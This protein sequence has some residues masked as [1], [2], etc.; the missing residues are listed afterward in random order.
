M[1]FLRRWDKDAL[2]KAED[3]ARRAEVRLREAI[4]LLPE[5]IV[6]LDREGRYILWNRRYAETYHASADLFEV[7]VRFEDSLRV[8]VARGDYPEALGREE[9]WLAE[10]LARMADPDERHEQRL[11]DG[12]WIMIEER[13]TADGGTIGIRVDITELKQQ[14]EA[15]RIALV[16]AE[17]ASKAKSDFLSNMS[18]EIRTPLNGV[19]GL[20]GVL[21]NGSLDPKQRS[22]V[23][24]IVA[25]ANTLEEL[26]TDLLM[27]S[28]LDAGALAL[29]NRPFRLRDVVEETVAHYR[30]ETEAK[31]LALT[32]DIQS[33]DDEE[34]LGDPGRIRQVL[35]NFLSNAVKFT[36]SGG[37]AVTLRTEGVAE[38][39]RQVLEVSDTGIGFDPAETERLFR[40]FEQA[41]ASITRSFGGTGLGLAICRQLVELM[42]G[43]IH[44]EGRPGLG[45]RFSVALALPLAD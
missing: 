33:G 32:V 20:A 9:E 15:L 21:A 38:T 17:A 31:G 4:D 5:G 19:V 41:D 11:A 44:A 1:A 30:P 36:A 24:T 3:D 26:L 23:E 2:N 13:K 14:A 22:L 29:D 8:G 39:A 18:H 25:S 12:R 28:R 40:R 7:G 27:Y 45:A 43:T 10:R 42:G 34:R 35:S 6:F 37:V 16:R